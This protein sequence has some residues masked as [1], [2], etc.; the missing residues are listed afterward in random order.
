[1]NIIFVKEGP[2]YKAV[3]VNNL[4]KAL[5]PYYPDARFICYTDDPKGVDIECIPLLY[6]LRKWWNKLVLFSKEFPAEGKCILFDLDIKVVRDPREYITN[7]HPLHTVSAYWKRDLPKYRIRHAF[8]TIINS[9]VLSWT[10]HK[11]THIWEH[12]NTNRDYFMRKYRG[13]DG[14]IYNEKFNIRHHEDGILSRVESPLEG[15]AIESWNNVDFNEFGI[16][17]QKSA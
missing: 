14:F 13:I 4:F 9:S 11:Q 10:N 6:P 8:N 17:V 12:F 16:T 1:M 3:H 2:A 5:R 15:A 7:F